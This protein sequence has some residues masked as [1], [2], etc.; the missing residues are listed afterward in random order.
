MAP[1]K[2]TRLKVYPTIEGYLRLTWKRNPPS[3]NV[4]YYIVYRGTRREFVADDTSL[5]GKVAGDSFLDTNVTDATYYFYKVRAAVDAENVSP[6]S[7][8]IPGRSPVGRI[9][10]QVTVFCLIA[11]AFLIF[12]YFVY[13]W[14]IF[15]SDSFVL[16][17][18][19]N[20]IFRE[21][22]LTAI[23]NNNNNPRI[24]TVYGVARSSVSD[25][26]ASGLSDSSGI[27]QIPFSAELA[28]TPGTGFP[29]S[30]EI[31]LLVDSND[32]KPG[33]FDGSVVIQGNEVSS[34]PVKLL[35]EP[36]IVQAIIISGIGILV[37]ILLWE[38]IKYFKK[39]NDE[40]ARMALLYDATKDKV[41]ADRV[42]E[43]YEPLLLQLSETNFQLSTLYSAE[44]LSTAQTDDLDK[45]KTQ[46]ADLEKIAK[47]MKELESYHR[48]SAQVN[49]EAAS[50]KSQQIY[51]YISR[52]LNPR[53]LWSKVIITEFGSAMF[54]ISLG[55]FGLLSNEFVLGLRTIGPFETTVL[56]G[57]GLG[58]GSLKEFV[59]K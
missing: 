32:I 38:F 1:S 49:N 59:D 53:S 43:E 24:L 58:I 19:G 57:L 30:S 27:D 47:P 29:T 15:D 25:V 46:R 5:I 31:N 40:Q 7:K 17:L 55:I 35:T 39:N 48:L 26:E 12:F 21:N 2:P 36:M 22:G 4:V 9:L 28:A 8:E 18:D 11:I 44:K 52:S 45:L 6:E 20:P 3:E 10:E 23:I 50:R 37:S 33:I 16:N 34:I 56:F 41:N 54:G 14:R 51:N 13:D 42:H